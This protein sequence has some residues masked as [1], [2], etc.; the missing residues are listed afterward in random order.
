VM[1]V[2]AENQVLTKIQILDMVK[3]NSR[4]ERC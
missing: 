4:K 2:V 1:E 3:E